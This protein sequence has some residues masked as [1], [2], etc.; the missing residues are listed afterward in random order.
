MQM[1]FA[2][3]AGA[4][5]LQRNWLKGLARNITKGGLYCSFPK[6]QRMLSGAFFAVQ[7]LSVGFEFR[8]ALD[9]DLHMS[10]E[11]FLNHWI[12]SWLEEVF[13]RCQ[14]ST[15]LTRDSK[16]DNQF[17]HTTG[18]IYRKAQVRDCKK[19]TN[20]NQYA[21]RDS[22][23]SQGNKIFGNRRLTRAF[24]IIFVFGFAAWSSGNDF[25]PGTF[26]MM[27]AWFAPP[28][29]VNNAPCLG[30]LMLIL[31]GTFAFS[32]TARLCLVSGRI[33]AVFTTL[34]DRIYDTQPHKQIQAHL[35]DRSAMKIL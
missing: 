21:E 10:K 11:K 8:H 9:E 23:H 1:N 15:C 12:L 22:V 31:E 20:S 17:L 24:C 16:S 32:T 28:E 19:S 29:D 3:C 4:A 5:S 35:L 27:L 6:K 13:N 25:F 34:Q 2:T 33:A 18:K 7:A 14:R 26:F 30:C